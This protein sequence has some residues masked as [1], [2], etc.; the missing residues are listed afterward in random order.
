MRCWASNSWHPTLTYRR[1][2][3][4]PRFNPDWLAQLLIADVTIALAFTAAFALGLLRRGQI[5]EQF[6]VRERAELLERDA[7]RLA[8]LAVADERSRI[9][10]EMHDIIAHSLASIV[11]LAEGGRLNASAGASRD[12]FSKIGAAGRG[13]LGDVKLLLRGVDAE[14]DVAPI[15]GLADIPALADSTRLPGTP[16]I[17]VS[18]LGTPVDLPAGMQAAMY[19]VAQESVTNMLKHAPGAPG[20]LEVRWFDDHVQ[21]RAVNPLVEGTSPPASDRRGIAGMRERAEL[22]D[23]TL[24]VTTTDT[25][26]EVLAIWPLPGVSAKEAA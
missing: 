10:R 5:V 4:T 6:R 23:G 1:G 21:L 24:T 22:F 2:G 7:H 3:P 17:R 25:S 11:T 16:G 14:G 19:R 13:A 18:T 9:A 12:L 15:R 20:E 8:E 26:F